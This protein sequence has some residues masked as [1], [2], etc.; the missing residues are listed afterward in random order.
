MHR[1]LYFCFIL[2]IVLSYS[3]F[4]DSMYSTSL[5]KRQCIV[6]Y[7]SVS[8]YSSCFRI[9]FSL[10]QC[11]QHLF[12]PCLQFLIAQFCIR[13]I[14]RCIYFGLQRFNLHLFR[15]LFFWFGYFGIV[16][17][18]QRI[19]HSSTVSNNALYFSFVSSFNSSFCVILLH[20]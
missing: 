11:T 18:I 13:H 2:L 8:Y 9:P 19:F 16:F 6:S 12:S 7:I 1:V 4:I 17:H 15:N 5:P 20:M 14:T 10:T 3:F